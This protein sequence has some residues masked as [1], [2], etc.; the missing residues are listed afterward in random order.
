MKKAKYAK[1]ILWYCVLVAGD[2]HYI[3]GIVN[4]MN[5]IANL[6]LRNWNKLWG[7]F[8]FMLFTNTPFCFWDQTK[9]WVFYIFANFIFKTVDLLS[10]QEIV[11]IL[12]W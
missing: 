7:I 11:L 10:V 3:Q 9:F 4:E 6:R 8:L 2:S 1:Q 5:F 12:L